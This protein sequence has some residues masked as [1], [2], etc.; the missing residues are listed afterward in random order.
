MLKNGLIDRTK[1]I[2]FFGKFS[3]KTGQKQ[4]LKT[5]LG[6]CSNL[7]FTK[8]WHFWRFFK[9]NGLFW[10]KKFCYKFEHSFHAKWRLKMVLNSDF[11]S[12]QKQHNST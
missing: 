9:E 7:N 10:A 12:Y 2:T 11:Y 6:V 8:K 5:F 4:D 1:N 3:T